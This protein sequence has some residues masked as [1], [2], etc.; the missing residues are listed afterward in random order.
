MTLAPGLR[1]GVY[2]IAAPV[3]AGGMGVVYR[4]R[5]TSLGRDVAL[6]VLPDAFSSDPERL[7]R[8]AREARLLA[9][10]NHPNIAAIYGFQ[11][12]IVSTEAGPI[13][14]R[15][16]V[17]EFVDGP[18]LAARLAEG[19][20]PLELSLTIARQLADALE[21]AHEQGIVHRDLKPANIKLT[22]RASARSSDPHEGPDFSGADAADLTVKVLDF[23][24]AKALTG[25][26][27]GADP[28]N[29]PTL[30]AQNTRHGVILGTA[31]YMSPEQAR[32][33][34]VDKR[35]DIWA[36]GVVLYEL[37][38][39]R[40]A[41]DGEEIS[42]VLACVITKEPDWSAL[43]A[44]TPG[45]IRT[46]LRRCLVKDRRRR[47][48]DI[49]DARLDIDEALSTPGADAAP[50]A[51][52]ASARLPAT[53]PPAW[54]R[55]VPWAL[56]GTLAGILAIVWA[57]PAGEP[58]RPA[59]PLHL[60]AAIGADAS[61]SA[62]DQGAAA[63][64][65]PDGTV[66]AFVGRVADRPAQLF[67]RKLDQLEP[68]PL[69]GTDGAASPFF[70]PDG[71]WLGFFADRKLKKV[72]IRGGAPV[73]LCDA[74][75]GRGGDWLDDGTIVFTPGYGAG[76]NLLSVPVDGG[77]PKPFIPLQPGEAT[78]RWPQ[79]LPGGQAILY[80]SHSA[81]TGFQD[82]S[83][84]VHRLSD[85]ARTIVQ[86]GAHY[87]RYLPSGHV[88]YV[89]EGTLFAVPFD[90]ERLAVA[91]QPTPVVSEVVS[92]SATGGAQFA[93]SRSGTLVYL[94]G[95]PAMY[96]ANIN[97]PIQWLTRTGQMTTLRAS[98]SG[99]T[100]PT[101]SPDGQRLAMAQVS[102]GPGSWDIWILDW[103]REIETRLTLDP[104][105]DQN[106]VWTPDG[107]RITFGSARADP[108][109]NNIYWQR[110]NGSGGVQRLTE[111]RNPQVP[112]SWHPGGRLLAF[113]EA[114]PQTGRDILILPITG[115]EANGWKPGT[116]TVLIDG[117]AGETGA[118]FSPDGRWLA[119]VSN[120]TGRNEV[121]VQPFQRPGAR[122][123]ISADGGTDP[124]WSHARPELLF[125]TLD[126]RQVMTASYG[127]DGESFRAEKSRPWTDARI[128]PR[129]G[130]SFALHPDGERVAIAPDAEPAAAPTLDTVVFIF[131]FFDE[132]RRLAPATR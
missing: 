53:H 42:D 67:L 55:A 115:D 107:R 113:Q 8:F 108:S 43:P 27:A 95:G 56:A 126:R 9:S 22:L 106:P 52:T 62:V 112:L 68:S 4:A 19:P 82:A 80:T 1:I 25:E 31:A 10:L 103:A 38:A 65:S 17:L 100:A 32:G 110:A 71:Q 73:T 69:E 87:G 91:G 33:K 127:I 111:S 5:D 54:R 105:F 3:G 13:A 15:G 125:S 16:L 123:Q 64:L 99:W 90:M 41:F 132:L 130:S 84:V 61:L 97:A 48:A 104:G 39:G 21:A 37:L 121:Y 29:S 129:F 59:P 78:Q 2:E 79:I 94:S 66:L 20:V 120:E 36:F 44:T 83:V 51:A 28:A 7:A 35:A 70:S 117:P 57:R 23:G 86:R 58:E 12:A 81:A 124:A 98:A 92:S 40:R 49:A 72:S 77:T 45:P 114:N 6:K 60:A 14:L 47:L 63:A 89:H 50:P 75:N 131:N 122:L 102:R 88:L 119:Y 11:E 93:T 101:F 116:P 76:A 26:P 118:A 128:T 46:L 34:V 18:T 74:S 96:T 85:G 109:A 24:L 30:T